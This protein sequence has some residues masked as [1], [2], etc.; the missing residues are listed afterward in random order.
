LQFTKMHGIGNDF[1]MIDA[2]GSNG[3]A[4][5]KEAQD[6][7]VWLCD[8]KFGVG[9]DGVILL[10]ASSAADFQ[11]RMFNPD[12][13]EAEMC[14]NGIRCFA[15]FAYDKGL[16]QKTTLRVETGAG[17]LETVAHVAGGKVQTVTVDMGEAHLVP[18][19][20][21]VHLPD[22]VEGPIVAAPLC[23]AGMDYAITCV[24]MG[25]PHCVVFVDDVESFPVAEIGPKF[26]RHPVFPRRINTEFIEVLGPSEVRMRVWERGAGE[27]LACGTG[28]CATAVACALNG[29]TGRDVTVHLAGGDLKIAWREDNRVMMTGPAAT[30]FEGVA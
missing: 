22:V 29:K 16:T 23:I 17:L 9:A 11:M 4:L 30:V 5:L 25:N 15:K 10:L 14:G 2:T 19:E 7:A 6:R 13:S 12:G 24:S 18:K 26:E 8:R 20:I 3:V 21:P 28:A 27:T 1:V